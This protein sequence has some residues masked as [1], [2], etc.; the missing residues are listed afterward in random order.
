MILLHK[1]LLPLSA[2]LLCSNLLSQQVANQDLSIYDYQYD[3]LIFKHTEFNEEITSEKFTHTEP[4]RSEISL[5]RV[6]ILHKNIFKEID[7]SFDSL[8]KVKPNLINQN[9]TESIYV[10]S[11]CSNDSLDCISEKI[12][13]DTIKD[14]TSNEPITQL[15]PIYFLSDDE[16]LLNNER[17]RINALRPYELIYHLGF[18]LDIDQITDSF[19]FNN[20]NQLTWSLDGSITIPKN[21]PNR[22]ELDIQWL[23][24][25]HYQFKPN[26]GAT[27]S[28]IDGL[29]R[30]SMSA[31]QTITLD[32]IYYFDH[33]A[34]GVIVTIQSFNAQIDEVPPA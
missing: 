7:Q 15:S 31:G 29:K 25:Y 28:L 11:P 24:D 26:D 22:I 20:L 5:E 30:Y 18:L 9:L 6:N 33:P 1:I 27:L 10:S 8:I 16:L 17:D 4:M 32:S 14:Q 23:S 3:F 19:R 34:F 2:S 12:L 21:Q 13:Y